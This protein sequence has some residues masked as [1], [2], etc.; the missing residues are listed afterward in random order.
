[1]K[2][3]SQDNLIYVKI[4]DV[5]NIGNLSLRTLQDRCSKN[6]YVCRFVEGNGGKQYE[7]L[8][9][10]LEP[11]IQEKIITNLK[12]SDETCPTHN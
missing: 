1:L 7:I 3:I 4:K 12:P 5:A 2:E 9:T 11:E 10:S 6:K 8:L